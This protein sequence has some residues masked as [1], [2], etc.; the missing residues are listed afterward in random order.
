MQERRDAFI[1]GL[2]GAGILY[3]CPFDSSLSVGQKLLL[4]FYTIGKS[5]SKRL[6]K[7]PRVTQLV[8]DRNQNLNPGLAPNLGSSHGVPVC[9]GFGVDMGE[10][11]LS[12]N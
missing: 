11:Q 5:D 6:I 3:T 4:P 8:T 12:S 10:E 9:M 2:R 1:R 7:W